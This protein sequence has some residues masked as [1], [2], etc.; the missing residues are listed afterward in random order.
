MLI[1][2]RSLY[3]VPWIYSPFHEAQLP[4]ECRQFTILLDDKCAMDQLCKYVGI[5][6][7]AATQISEWLELGPQGLG[8]QEVMQLSKWGVGFNP[9]NNVVLVLRVAAKKTDFCLE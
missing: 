7:N 2:V 1:H 8:V 3:T 4:R 5:D 6:Q 9:T